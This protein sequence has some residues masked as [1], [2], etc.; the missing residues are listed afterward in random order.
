MTRPWKSV[1]TSVA[2]P[3][4]LTSTFSGCDGANQPLA[5]ESD[6]A[7]NRTA[8]MAVDMTASGKTGEK[9]H[10][11]LRS[12]GAVSLAVLLRHG[13]FAR[14]VPRVERPITYR[15]PVAAW[16]ERRRTQSWAMYT[17]TPGTS[18]PTSQRVPA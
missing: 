15:I 2:G 5:G 7:R 9:Q 13:Q 10:G 12:G 14:P 11:L 4:G 1:S 18:N 6:A 17:N 3:P 8:P 16:V